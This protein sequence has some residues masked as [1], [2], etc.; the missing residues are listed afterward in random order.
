MLG[1]PK[2]RHVQKPSMSHGL[3]WP[4]HPKHIV[5]DQGVHNK[6]RVIQLLQ[7][8]GV[9]IRQVGVAVPYQQGTGE[10]HGGTFS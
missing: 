6:G 3:H 2:A 9:N 5:V 8:N 4:V 7:S 10:R 1:T